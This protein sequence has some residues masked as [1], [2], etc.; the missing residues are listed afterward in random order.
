MLERGVRNPTL[1]V[2]DKL[3][4]ALGTTMGALITEVEARS[5]AR[6]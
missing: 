5:K 3:S 2:I 6:R 4:R 1:M